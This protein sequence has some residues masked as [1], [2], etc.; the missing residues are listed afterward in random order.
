[1]GVLNRNSLG[2]GKGIE[3]HGIVVPISLIILI[4]NN[5]FPFLGLKPP[6]RR[7]GFTKLGL[8]KLCSFIDLSLI[9]LFIN[10][11]SILV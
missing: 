10:N 6:K 9:I 4:Q 11:M 5:G 2:L 7:W 3:Q 1:M 8:K